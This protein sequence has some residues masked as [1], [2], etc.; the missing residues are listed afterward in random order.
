MRQFFNQSSLQ[1]TTIKY[2]HLLI[3]ISSVVA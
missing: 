1:V 2:T 3:S